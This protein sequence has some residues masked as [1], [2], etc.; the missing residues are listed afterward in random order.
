MTTASNDNGRAFEYIFAVVLSENIAK[1]RKVS[2]LQNSSLM[3][4]RNAWDNVSQGTKSN[5]RI[6]AQAAWSTICDAE[7][8]MTENLPDVLNVELQSDSAGKIGDVRDVLLIRSNIHWEI[9]FSLK[10]NN[11]AVKHSRLSPTID[12]GESWYG[13]PCSIEYWTRVMPIFDRLGVLQKKR[14]K[15]GDVPDKDE[16]IYRPILEAFVSE[17]KAAYRL[18]ASV[19]TNMVEYLMGRFDFYKIISN[20]N[21]KNT[22]VEAYNNKGTLNKHASGFSPRLTVPRTELPSRILYVDIVPNNNTTVEM[23]MDKGWFITFRIHNASS[24]VEK[25]LKFDVQLKGVPTTLI[26]INCPWNAALR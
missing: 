4:A 20:E 22:V 10:H 1:F 5:L 8:F 21:T 23:S 13:V 9:G 18:H 15:W 25:S 24:S 11:F 12:F 17:I 3:A 19:P 16:A 7:Y 2:L 14:V 6:A 26:T